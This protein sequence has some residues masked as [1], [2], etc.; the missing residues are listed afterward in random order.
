[1]VFKA[2][3][4]GAAPHAGQMLPGEAKALPSTAAGRGARA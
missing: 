4:A 3:A 1:M 2:F